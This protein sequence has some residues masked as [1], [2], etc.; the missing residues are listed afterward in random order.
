MFLDDGIPD[1]DDYSDDVSELSTNQKENKV[2]LNAPKAYFK[3]SDYTETVKVGDNVTLK[4]DVVNTNG[5]C[6]EAHSLCIGAFI[7]HFNI[8]FNA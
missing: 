5:K 6:K 1:G 8:Q 4:C 7:L 2:D 3:L